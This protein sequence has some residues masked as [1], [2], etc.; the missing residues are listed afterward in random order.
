MTRQAERDTVQTARRSPR[1]RL[2]EPLHKAPVAE[3]A[4]TARQVAVLTRLSS[5]Q[6][7]QAV[8]ALQNTIGNA[9][10]NRVLPQ[11][12]A[13]PVA[14][15]RNTAMALMWF[16]SVVTPIED[17]RAA[18]TAA[19]PNTPGARR[20]VQRAKATVEG[21]RSMYE[22]RGLDLM[23]G[24]L[25]S[26]AAHLL[27]ILRLLDEQVLGAKPFSQVQGDLPTDDENRAIAN[28]LDDPAKTDWLVDVAATT[29]TVRTILNQSLVPDSNVA[30]AA[31]LIA[32]R[33]IPTA[34]RR[35]NETAASLDESK[36]AVAERMR[37][38]ARRLYAVQAQLDE[39]LSGQLYSPKEIGDQLPDF[40]FMNLLGD[41]LE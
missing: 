29:T 32:N 36:Q 41:Q 23:A 2:V 17:A 21:L 4:G 9:A 34:E 40:G 13:I 15:P 10:T 6:R 33:A 1:F 5:V 24:R 39:H 25:E 8:L 16:T 30:I 27:I 26:F 3:V 31:N 12:R 7:S 20:D 28:G 18:L 19:N 37:A 22:A 35:G 14:A 11:A 38:V